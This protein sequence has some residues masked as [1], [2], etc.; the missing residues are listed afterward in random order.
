MNSLIT[1]SVGPLATPHALGLLVPCTAP[2]VR[3]APPKVSVGGLPR[4]PAP[5]VGGYN[6]KEQA[7]VR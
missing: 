5:K 6:Q 7:H 2:A 1:L 3:L 4:Q